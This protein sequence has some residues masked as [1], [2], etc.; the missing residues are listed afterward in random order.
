MAIRRVGH[1]G[2]A[3][4]VTTVAF[5]LPHAGPS[6][7][8]SPGKAISAPVAAAAASTQPVA[9]ASTGSRFVTYNGG[10]VTVPA[11]WPVIGLRVHPQTCV[12]SD[13]AAVYLGS[14][15][16]QSDCPA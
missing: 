15:G 6:P 14:P 8:E 2:V 10:R 16:S 3:C 11:T 7:A 4:A 9:A 13:R 1:A 12:R 5:V